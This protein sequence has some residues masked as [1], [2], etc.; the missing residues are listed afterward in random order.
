MAKILL[1][2]DEEGLRDFMVQVLE[3]AGHQLAEAGDGEE[4]L[5]ALKQDKFDLLITDVRM[6]RLDGLSLLPR[7][8]EAQPSLKVLVLTAHG[9]IK[10]AVEAMRLGAADYMSKPLESPEAL[11][12]MVSRVLMAGG[13]PL[14]PSTPEGLP[15]L[16]F[17][18]PSMQPVVHALKKVARTDATV[19][20]QG[21]SGVGKEVAAQWL[22]LSSARAAGPFV[23]VN[24]AAFSESLLE[25]E[26]FGHE[27]GAFTGAV[28]TRKGRLEV[29]EGGT[30]FLDEVGELK[31]ELQARLLRV[32]QE[33][34]FE[35][36]GG[37]K[38]LKADVRWVAAT[39][40][41]LQEMVR[42]GKFREDLYHRLAVFPIRI[43]PLRE[44]K[45]DILPLA[46]ALLPRIAER[47]GGPGLSLTPA[48]ERALTQASWPGNVRAL[49]NALERAAILADD[50]RLQPDGLGL[51]VT[52]A[53]P[54]APVPSV[55][56]E[57]APGPL[58]PLEDLE[59]EAIHQ[60]LEQLGGNRKR[61]A[62]ALGIGLRTLYDKLKKYGLG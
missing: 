16:T 32:L 30:F 28:Q 62:D 33:R 7:A 35:R 11:R 18:A 26:L 24:C 22:H 20:L 61:A 15:T 58:R 14:A 46:T 47:L 13:T 21:E 3:R 1:A 37:N 45:E 8:K 54:L 4:A 5:E 55:H 57:P 27:K 44:R 43:P 56:A 17:G 34:Q 59:K 60:A 23:A 49:A 36:V 42:E 2:E 48:A 51:E 31:P 29:A 39:N 41:D 50:H 25:S 19:L 10:G 53:E 38:L 6:P 52:E 9:S 40:R 12:R